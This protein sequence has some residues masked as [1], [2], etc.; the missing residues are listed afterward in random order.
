MNNIKDFYDKQSDY[1][2]NLGKAFGSDSGIFM[3]LTEDYI[4]NYIKMIGKLVQDENSVD[5]LFW[6]SMVSGGSDFEINGEK[7]E[8]TPE[9]VYDLFI[10]NPDVA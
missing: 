6:E 2:D 10:K 9:N 4:E 7:F 5:W 1:C 3:S 8:G